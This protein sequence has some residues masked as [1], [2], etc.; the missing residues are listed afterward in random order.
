MKKLIKKKGFTLIELIAVI[1]ILA[2]LGAILVPRIT[3]YR[4]KAKKSNYQS[5]AKV[6][7]N[8]TKAYNADAG[9]LIVDTDK[10]VDKIDNINSNGIIIDKTD[11][12]YK[13]LAD[14]GYTFAQIAAIANGDFTMNDDDT[15]SGI[16]SGTIE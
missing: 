4:T 14:A 2:I 12:S 10:L 9:T 15:I 1:A 6:I 11:E 5:S 13:K 7:I 16:A 3:G 8:A